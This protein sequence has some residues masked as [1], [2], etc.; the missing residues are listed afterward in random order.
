MTRRNRQC[1]GGCRC[2]GFCGGLRTL[3]GGLRGGLIL[4]HNEMTSWLVDDSIVI[5]AW[6]DELS[7][8]QDEL[9]A[10]QDELSAWQDELL[11]RQ[12]LTMVK[13]EEN[14]IEWC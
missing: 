13:I 6:Q 1:C 14:T 11:A 5:Q 4:Q 10:W 2:C 12:A 3:R 7:A 9:L 8:W